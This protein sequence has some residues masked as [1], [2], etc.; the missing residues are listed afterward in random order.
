MAGKKKYI[1]NNL[2]KYRRLA[3]LKQTDVVRELG[4]QSA[5]IVSRW[6]RGLTMPSGRYLLML[7]NLYH[8]L[9]AQL[10]YE[11]K[12]ELAAQEPGLLKREGTEAKKNTDRAP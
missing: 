9:V 3:G 4:L 11:Y 1:P 10:Y 5:S 12:K 8:T 6:E 2:R 7:E